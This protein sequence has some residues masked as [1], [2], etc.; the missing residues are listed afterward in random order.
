MDGKTNTSIQETAAGNA[1]C[2][3][4]T[5]L[6]WLQSFDISLKQPSKISELTPGSEY[7]KNF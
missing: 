7:L 2:K 3:K 6:S 4:V 1:V 5:M